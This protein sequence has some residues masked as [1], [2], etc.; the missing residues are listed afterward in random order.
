MEEINNEADYEQVV[1][2]IDL[3]MTKGSDN[4]SKEE[5]EQ[6]RS[7]AKIAQNYEQ[8]KYQIDLL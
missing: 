1:A 6:I 4:V 5:L 2:K 7:L 3:L 8:V